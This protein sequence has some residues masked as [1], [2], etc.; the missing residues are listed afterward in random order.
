MGWGMTQ[1][2]AAYIMLPN[3]L[4]HGFDYA[5]PREAL[6]GTPLAVGDHVLVDF[7]KRPLVGVVWGLVDHIDYPLEKLKPITQALTAIPPMTEDMRKLVEWVAWYYAAPMGAVLKMALPLSVKQV[8]AGH[9]ASGGRL[10]SKKPKAQS[11]KPNP[12]LA[13]LNPQQQTAADELCQSVGSGFSVSV[14]DGVTGSGK[15]EVYFA[16]VQTAMEQGKQVLIL[17]PEIGLSIQW[18][19]RFEARFGFMP[20]LWHSGVTP[21]RKRNSYAALAR[22]EASVVVGARSALFLPLPH[23]GLI[24]VDEEH[25]GSYKQEEGV[26]YHARDTAIMRAKITGVPIVLASATPAVETWHNVQEGRYKLVSLPKRF[27]EASLPDT[28]LIDMRKEQLERGDF[29]G[30]TLKRRLA[31]NLAEGNQSL[32]FLNRRGYAPLMLCRACGYRFACEACSS[33]L[34]LHKNQHRLCCH[35]CGHEQFLPKACPSCKAEDQLHACGPG[36]ER[37]AEE[38]TLLLPQAKVEFVSSDASGEQSLGQIIPRMEAGEIDVLIG[39]QMVA[40][41]HHFPKLSLVGV[42]DADLGLAGGDLRGMERTYQLL[43]QISGRAG[44]AA[45]KGQALV[46]TFFPEHPALK[47]LCGEDRDAFMSQELLNR[48][49]GKMPPFSR[50]LAVILESKREDEVQAAAKLM[51]Q[52]FPTHDK[53]RLFGPAPAPLYKVRNW[54]RWRLLV[55]AD[56]SLGIQ[57][58]A[59]EWQSRLKLPYGVKCKMDVDPYG[60]M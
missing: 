22:G 53:A 3:H 37:I 44:R 40:K 18:L 11:P 5:L 23:L 8:E 20:E 35:H 33:W 41:G 17:L 60:F 57:S 29:L 31:E 56:K 50:L 51:A 4:P 48:Q 15:T 1:P 46:Q 34:V 26:M 2:I 13:T 12:Q 19:K 39:T 45:I 25:D 54:Y 32:L 14:L 9:W 10:Q 42:V 52:H 30:E 55:V 38:V 49:Y 43:H 59:D 16:A 58:L 28:S 21:A 47:A 24:I 6:G 36:V 7:A 27:A